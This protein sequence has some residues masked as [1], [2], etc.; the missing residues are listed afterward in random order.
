MKHHLQARFA[1]HAEAIDELSQS[2]SAFDELLHRYG[3]V[4]ERRGT[5]PPRPRT[6]RATRSRI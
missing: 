3:H 2:N 4:V 5:S 6:R 1:E